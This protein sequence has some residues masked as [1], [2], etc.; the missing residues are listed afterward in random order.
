MAATSRAGRRV[1]RICRFSQD[2]D[3]CSVPP[4]T[5]LSKPFTLEVVLVPRRSRQLRR[6][7][8]RDRLRRQSRFSRIWE[9]TPT[10]SSSTRWSNPPDTSMNLQSYVLASLRPAETAE[11]IMSIERAFFLSCPECAVFITDP[12]IRRTLDFWF[13]LHWT[14]VLH[15]TI[16]WEV[17]H[18]SFQ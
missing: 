8:E 16:I 17:W 18:L 1:Q 13:L 2:F 4:Q 14:I 9:S 11:R 15:Y 12:F 3:L 5:T 7:S 10:S 6:P